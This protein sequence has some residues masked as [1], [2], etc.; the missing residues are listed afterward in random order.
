M[1][2]EAS[3]DVPKD[4]LSRRGTIRH[5]HYVLLVIQD[6]IGADSFHKVQPERLAMTAVGIEAHSS[7]R[8]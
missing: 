1:S 8:M 2:L 6:L 3:L 4:R 5:S 7:R